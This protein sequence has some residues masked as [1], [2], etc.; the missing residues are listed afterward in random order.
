[1]NNQ[2][3]Y[4][5]LVRTNPMLRTLCNKLSTLVELYESMVARGYTC[6]WAV[7]LDRLAKLVR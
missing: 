1:M 6:P 3:E 5:E 7:S 2:A 4:A